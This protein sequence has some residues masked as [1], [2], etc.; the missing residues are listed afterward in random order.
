[1]QHFLIPYPLKKGDL[2]ID[3]KELLHQMRDVL[4]FRVG[5]ECMLL[6]GEGKKALATVE[7][8]NRKEAELKVGDVESG[9][10]PKRALRLFFALPKKP[11]TLE[12]IL[13]KGTELGVTDFYPIITERTQVHHLRQVDRLKRIVK[14]ALEQSE[15]LYLPQLHDMRT[16][17]DVLNQMPSGLLLVG[18][19]WKYKKKLSEIMRP[20]TEDLNLLIGPEGGLSDEELKNLEK[21]GAQLFLLGETVLRMETAALAALSVVQFS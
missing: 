4:R 14:E 10:A 18:E 21:E 8:L 1:M 17:H 3:E 19:P 5:S 16:L 6:D 9:A 12:F 2:R 13:Q 11:A 20:V 15:G 7:T